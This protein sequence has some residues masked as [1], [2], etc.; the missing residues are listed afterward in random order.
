MIR[1]LVGPSAVT[2]IPSPSCATTAA[3]CPGAWPPAGRRP[4]P[5]ACTRLASVCANSSE[6]AFCRR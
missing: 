6:S 5:A 1:E 3:A 2:R 4:E